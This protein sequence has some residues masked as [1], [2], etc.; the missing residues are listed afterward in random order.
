MS[1]IHSPESLSSEPVPVSGIQQVRSSSPLNS[2]T[3]IAA[4]ALCFQTFFSNGSTRNS[5]LWMATGTTSNSWIVVHPFTH[6]VRNSIANPNGVVQSAKAG[7]MLVAISNDG[8]NNTGVATVYVSG[9]GST[10]YAV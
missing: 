4:N 6:V 5:V 1:F 9:G 7:Q 10:W 2:L 3:P 8:Y